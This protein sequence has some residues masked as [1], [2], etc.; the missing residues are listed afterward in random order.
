MNFQV[1]T[2]EFCMVGGYTEAVTNHRTVKIG[3]WALAR[4]WAPVQDNT[5]VVYICL[6]CVGV[7]DPMRSGHVGTLV[8]WK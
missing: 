6:R 3:G 1:T 2:Q 4:G 8:E 7:Y 5:S